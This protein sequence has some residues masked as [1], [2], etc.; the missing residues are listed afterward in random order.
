MRARSPGLRAIRVGLAGIALTLPARAGGSP[1]NAVLVVDPANAESLYVANHYRSAWDIPSRNLLYLSPTPPTYAQFS[2]ST[3][4][5]FL[6]SLENLRLADHADVVIL[7]PGGSFYVDAAG[8]V[9]DSCY[10]VQRFSSIAPYILARQSD[11]ILA[12]TEVSLAN[13]YCRFGDD[14]R[15]FDAGVGWASGVPAGSG[16]RYFIGAMLG[17][18]GGLGN[19]LAEVL[20]MIDR[21]VAVDGER[22]DGRIYYMHTNDPARSGPRDQAFPAAVGSIEAL[23]GSAEL[24]FA[25]LPLGRFDCQ[26]IMTGLAGPDI[27][28]ANL[29][30]LPG[31]FCDHLTSYAA[32]LDSPS[33]TKMTRWISKGASGTSGAVEEPCNYPGK[34]PHARLHVFYEQGLSLGE[35]WFRSMAFAPFQSLF[36]G[37]PLT[38]P[39]AYLPSVDLGGVPAG[40]AANTIAL[41]PVATTAHPTAEIAGFELLVDGVS[42]STCLPDGHFALDTTALADGVH[43]WRVL[44]YDDTPVRSVG[45]KSGTILVSNRGRGAALSAVTPSGDLR[46]RF[47]F[48]ASGSGGSVHE[49]RLL[50]GNRVV[51]ASASSPAVLSVCGQNLGAGN[52]ELVLEAR[53][54]DGALAL[55]APVELAIAYTAGAPSGSAPVASSYTKHVL[56]S[57]AAVVELPSSFDDDLPS[58][59][60][61]VLSGPAQA[62]LIGGGT[63]PYRILRPN[64]GASGIDSMTFRVTTPSGTSNVATVTIVYD[65]PLDCPEP[66]NYCVTTPNSTGQG[67]VIG[68]SGSTSLGAND[69]QL[70]AF[71]CPAN[72]FGIFL[73]GKDA[74]QIPLGNGIR[75]VASPFYRLGSTTTNGFGD[76]TFAVDFTRHPANAGSGAITIGS[77][78]RFQLWFRDGA[79]GGARTNLTDGLLVTICP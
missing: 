20:A 74:A 46:T 42:R 32:T 40:P 33:Q 50:Q 12:G 54:T 2:A 37:D 22:P 13:G 52:A 19:T 72:R 26:G 45:R 65:A 30:V 66:S 59:G 9:A 53:F 17:Y 60:T 14:A 73:Y 58:A 47:D 11:L 55:S 41:Y 36:I 64:P 3:L 6:G 28:G 69:L 48:S 23:G 1:E 16:T 35:S 29:G 44:A 5:G 4:P 63:G 34:F 77:T 15:A 8:L 31:A 21:S 38:R 78:Q 61:A 51:A 27:D 57:E 68:A 43:E 39:F 56:A 71:G 75:C 49:L 18:T 79:A 24:L 76:A 62:T 67:A 7:P 10:P 70:L 25:D